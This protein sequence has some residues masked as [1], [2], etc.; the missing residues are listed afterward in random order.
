[1]VWNFKQ[2][3]RAFRFIGHSDAVLS[4]DYNDQHNLI[5]SV[6]AACRLRQ[7]RL[8]AQSKSAPAWAGCVAGHVPEKH[9]CVLPEQASKDKSVR[10]W[11]PTA[12]GRSTVLKAHTAAVRACAFSQNG[13]LLATASDDKTVK[14]GGRRMVKG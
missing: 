4:V 12:E 2:D 6:G 3:M 1:M 10:L 5:A 8:C 13:R 14:V 7:S 11:R 9:A